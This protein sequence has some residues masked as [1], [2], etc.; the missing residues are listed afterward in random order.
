MLKRKLGLRIKFWFTKMKYRNAVK[1]NGYTVCYAFP[2]SS[3]EFK[4]PSGGGVSR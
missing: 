2:N 4:F 1:F 3:I